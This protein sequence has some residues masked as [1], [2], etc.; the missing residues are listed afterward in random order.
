[1]FT[2]FFGNY[3]LN[4][5]LAT[6]QQLSAALELQQKIHIKLGV[7]AINAGYM[8]AEQVDKLHQLQMHTDKRIGDLA[9]ELGYMTTEQ[10]NELLSSQK[11]GY[12]LLGQA[13]VESGSMTNGQFAIA[14]KA[15]KDATRIT[16][17]EFSD[18]KA[19]EVRAVICDFYGFHLAGSKKDLYADYV[20]LLLKNI[21]RFIGDDF[22][23]LPSSVETEYRC[24]EAAIQHIKGGER[25]FTAIEAESK[26]FTAFASRYA[27]ENFT[28]NDDYTKA[29]VGEFLNLHNGLFAVN[30]SNS[31]AVE[32]DLEPQA[33]ESNK[34][35]TGFV[36]AFVIAVGF[37]FGTVHFILSGEN[38]SVT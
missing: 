3:L 28:Q 5:H 37:P 21:I 35:L 4:N 12:L 14:L 17:N 27:Q 36:R 8:T 22:T 20:S 15:Y 9:V 32:L 26:V 24:E 30:A 23:L 11:S 10:V 34:L 38:P 1:M 25:L 16:D 6:P 7:L 18:N 29:S 31:L 13:L 33:Y 2:Q 19:S